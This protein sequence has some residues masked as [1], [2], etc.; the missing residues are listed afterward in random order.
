MDLDELSART[1]IQQVLV[2]GAHWADAFERRAGHWRIVNRSVIY[3]WAREL[4][5]SPGDRTGRR[6]PFPDDFRMDSPDSS[7][8]SFA[9]RT[10]ALGT[11]DA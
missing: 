1:E 10:K 3:D 5:L 8:P 4:T 7:D 6:M 2:I 11:P 9:L